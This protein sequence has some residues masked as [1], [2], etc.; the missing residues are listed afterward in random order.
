MAVVATDILQLSNMLVRSCNELHVLPPRFSFLLTLLQQINFW[1]LV[2]W[3]GFQN[4]QACLWSLE[5]KTLS[6]CQAN[7]LFCSS[8]FGLCNQDCSSPDH[9]P[10]CKSRTVPSALSF[11]RPGMHQWFG[12][13]C[14]HRHDWMHLHKQLSSRQYYYLPLEL[15]AYV[16]WLWPRC[17]IDMI[18]GSKLPWLSGPLGLYLSPWFLGP[19]WLP[20]WLS[21]HHLLNTSQVLC[22]KNIH[23]I[24]FAFC[25][26][27]Y[28]CLLGTIFW[29]SQRLRFFFSLM[30]RVCLCRFS[31]P[32]VFQRVA[33]FQYTSNSWKLGNSFG[34]INGLNYPMFGEIHSK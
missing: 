15:L 25:H 2:L 18:L 31:L 11:S 16:S 19:V 1:Q 14:I 17:F 22:T 34:G 32:V 33:F 6:L 26:K 28:M 3:V 7:L 8:D 13:P 29:G 4:T 5:S 10:A 12:P 23:A 20:A 9:S 30:L 24:A 27:W 21:L